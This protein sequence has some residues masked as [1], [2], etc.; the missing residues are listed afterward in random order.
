MDN[1]RSNILWRSLT[2]NRIG[3]VRSSK[4]GIVKKRVWN[5][6]HYITSFLEKGKRT[7]ISSHTLAVKYF[8]KGYDSSIHDVS[9][10]DRDSRNVIPE[11]LVFT[12]KSIRLTNNRF[13]RKH[14]PIPI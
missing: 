7:N 1:N 5:G 4:T 10:I 11:N 9:F 2:S 6:K 12:S 13:K 3:E 8:K 14:I